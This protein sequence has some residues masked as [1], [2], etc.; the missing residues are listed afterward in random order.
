MLSGTLRFEIREESQVGEAR[1][2]TVQ[3]AA[4]LGY[5]ETAT[6]KLALAVTE[7]GTN[8][9]KHAGAGGLLLV[10]FLA[11]GQRE[12]R[13]QIFALDR[14]PGIPDLPQALMDGFSTTGTAG[15]GLG[16]LIRLGSTF[17]IYSLPDRGT[18]IFLEIPF[19]S[20][21]ESSTDIGGVS[22]NFP[23]ETVCGDGWD[24]RADEEAD[25]VLVV[26]GLGHGDR[27]RE[28]ATTAMS[29]FERADRTDVARLLTTMDGALRKTRGGAVSIAR[30]S[31][32]L[33]RV[34][35]SGLGNVNGLIVQDG[36]HAQLVS[37][38]G[39]VGT[40]NGRAR[41]F[42][43]P[44]GPR[45]VLVMSSDGLSSRLEPAGYPGLFQRSAPLIAAV[46]LRDYTRHRDDATVAVV[47]GDAWRGAH[48]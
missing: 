18:A 34:D 6:A 35:Y 9:V 19:D 16:A 45:S 32:A 44:F 11:R 31:R 4:N 46:L 25:T 21:V 3:L 2:G 13:A 43:Y 39:I 38:N 42:S 10:Q 48:A 14:G 29:E 30:V 40:G 22:T 1:R 37:T 23:G 26:D 20:R 41:T 27:A 24:I 47:K 28:A 36:H 17:D 8:L 5:S 33:G 15:K 7:L 12:T